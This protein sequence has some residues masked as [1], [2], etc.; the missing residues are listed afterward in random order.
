MSDEI[1]TTIL[2]PAEAQ[3]IWGVTDFFQG[4]R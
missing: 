1:Y 4:I 3:V 2:A